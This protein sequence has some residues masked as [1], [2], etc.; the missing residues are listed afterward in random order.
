MFVVQA[1]WGG[2]WR[3]VSNGYSRERKAEAVAERYRKRTGREI[4]VRLI[5]MGPS[6]G[7]IQIG[8]V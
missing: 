3:D 1:H 8:G 6:R 2:R 7:R 5:Y 4:R